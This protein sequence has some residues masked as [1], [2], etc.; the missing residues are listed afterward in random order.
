MGQA[1]ERDEL[2][3]KL[4]ELQFFGQDLDP[5]QVV[6]GRNLTK[7]LFEMTDEELDNLLDVFSNYCI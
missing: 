6:S 1:E 3:G 2:V 5:Q 4:K 7:K